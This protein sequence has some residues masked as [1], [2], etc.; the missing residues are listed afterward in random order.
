MSY[1]R[2]VGQQQARD[3][4][5]VTDIGLSLQEPV[6]LPSACAL[7]AALRGCLPAQGHR[8][9]PLKPVSPVH[10]GGGS[11]STPVGTNGAQTTE[12]DI[13]KTAREGDNV[14][15]TWPFHHLACGW[16]SVGSS[17]GGRRGCPGH[18]ANIPQTQPCRAACAVHRGASPRGLCEQEGDLR[19]V[20]CSL[21][22]GLS[23]PR[24]R[25]PQ[26]RL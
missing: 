1:S 26:T 16:R 2:Q 21:G 19:A 7:P 23:C 24:E 11:M 15:S 18:A 25:G 20:A 13:G 12:G 10:T 17:F 4:T 6:H 9:A 14:G 8:Q 5:H 22:D 3:D